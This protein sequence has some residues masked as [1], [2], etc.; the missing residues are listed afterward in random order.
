MSSS[1][2][3]LNFSLSSTEWGGKI[4]P[5]GMGAKENLSVYVYLQVWL[6]DV[7][8]GKRVQLHSV[9]I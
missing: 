3:L 5:T 8:V 9:D 6:P 4:K 2:T 1:T 7:A